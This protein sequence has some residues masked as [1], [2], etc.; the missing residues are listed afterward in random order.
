M[1]IKNTD[2]FR[3][4]I[5]L[6]NYNRAIQKISSVWHNNYFLITRKQHPLIDKIIRQKHI[7][8][9]NIVLGGTEIFYDMIL[10]YV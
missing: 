2:S 10:L 7:I 9:I 6:Q 3:Q 8:V 1:S 4:V 5:H